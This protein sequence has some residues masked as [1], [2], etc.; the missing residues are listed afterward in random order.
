MNSQLSFADFEASVHRRT[1]GGTRR[2][3]AVDWMR[4]LKLVRPDVHDHIADRFID[5]RRHAAM[6]DKAR[7]VAQEL[8]G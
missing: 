8:W 7:K 1:A 6:L 3:V 4:T 5:P 2:E